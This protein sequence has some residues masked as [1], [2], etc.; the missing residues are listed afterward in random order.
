MFAAPFGRIFWKEYRVH[1]PLWL[2]LFSIGCV[3]QIS[4]WWFV[5]Q[6]EA[7]EVALWNVGNMFTVMY[8]IG[9]GALL[10]ASER[11]ERTSDWLLSLSVPPGPTLLAKA[12]FAV[13]S[14]IALQLFLAGLT[15]LLLGQSPTSLMLLF[16]LVSLVILNWSYLGSLL[17]KRVLS[18]VPLIFLLCLL[19]H[20]LF[21]AGLVLL[22]IRGS[23]AFY[24]V[25]AFMILE[26]VALAANVWIGWRWCQG[27]YIDGTMIAETF[28]RWTRS[29]SSVIRPSLAR[30][31]VPAQA[32]HEQ[33]W[34]RTWQRLVWQERN[35]G[36]AY[37]VFCCGTI[38]FA[39]L[40][41]LL[42]RNQ[43]L[44]YQQQHTVYLLAA[45]L[46]FLSL[47]MGLLGFRSE[48]RFQHP[49]FVAIRGLSPAAIWLAKQAVWLT[50]AFFLSCLAVIVAIAVEAVFWIAYP[51]TRF[52]QF[53]AG[54]LV[55]PEVFVY[56]LLIGYASGHLAA[57]LFQRTILAAVFGGLLNL[58]FL[59]WFSIVYSM[60]VPLWW[61]MG[62]PIVAMMLIT[63]WQ[64]KPWMLEHHSWSRRLKLLLAL[65]AVPVTM[66]GLL[67]QF[68]IGEAQAATPIEPSLTHGL[69]TA[70]Q[71]GPPVTANTRDRRRLEQLN[72]TPDAQSSAVV[73]EL[74]ALLKSGSVSFPP[75]RP[76]EES[77]NKATSRLH[78]ILSSNA[79]AFLKE[80]LLEKSLECHLASLRL[81]SLT[82]NGEVFQWLNAS[83]V[84]RSTLNEMVV[85]ANH[86]LQ[87]PD[88]IHA[89]IKSVEAELARFPSVTKGIAHSF[90][91]DR[92]SWILSS[93]N[94]LF[95]NLTQF[96]I[97]EVEFYEFGALPMLAPWER[98]RAEILI[99]RN[100]EISFAA[101]LVL[102]T[103]L[104]SP[105]LS[106]KTSVTSHYAPL[107][108]A[109]ESLIL[110][111]PLVQ[112]THMQLGPLVDAVLNH[113]ANIRAGITRM[114]LL[115]Y[116]LKEGGL[117]ERLIQLMESIDGV[118][119][120]DP[121]SDRLFEFYP[122]F[123]LSTG[124]LRAAVVPMTAKDVG[125]IHDSHHKDPVKVDY[126]Q[127]ST[128]A[129]IGKTFIQNGVTSLCLFPIPQRT[130][131]ED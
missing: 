12:G 59:T 41:V 5:V 105:T 46:T 71:N 89:A 124:N 108:Q 47:A 10:F 50:R 97:P 7:R 9:C 32:E 77:A 85:W 34:R 131:R 86:P 51:E 65:I 116:R 35:R 40:L 8:V 81:A 120:V 112:R 68:R 60:N 39:I 36:S 83:G 23:G 113:H 130:G 123:L 3:L 98:K 37:W 55:Q 61:S 99:T 128:E 73:A 38:A 33:S 43:I 2:S 24:I 4:L 22:N 42:R 103:R 91:G 11:E 58:G 19:P 76:W 21:S 49:R 44:M 13:V 56:G 119:L 107:V 75:K 87:T 16:P 20:Y 90:Q 80:G 54:V 74:I 121:W 117:P 88:S 69:F 66:I 53:A 67:A 114:A 70:D 126:Q 45:S 1:Q 27:K 93:R 96:K 118:N 52:L 82:G 127:I 15:L 78:P 48:T 129:E 84:V 92:K 6:S 26:L 95:E 25:R 17:C 64:T 100:A 125:I 62:I 29:K 106:A 28:T 111:T 72:M 14:T 109:N 31:R 94:E 122:S 18:S 104:Q 110:S 101:I 57:L 102:E 30:S 115:A 79:D 63:L